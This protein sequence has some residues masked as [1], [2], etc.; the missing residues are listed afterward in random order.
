M[1]RVRPLTMPRR[2]VHGAVHGRQDGSVHGV[3]H[4]RRHGIVRG[5]VYALCH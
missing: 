5:E 2:L 4:G 3:V 1:P